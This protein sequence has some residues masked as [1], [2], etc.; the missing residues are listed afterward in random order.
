MKHLFMFSMATCCILM[1]SACGAT[2][3]QKQ[4]VDY[5][6][7]KYETKFTFSDSVDI[8]NMSDEILEIVNE[9]LKDSVLNL[10]ST[11]ADEALKIH[12][13]DFSDDI[14]VEITETENGTVY[15]DNYLAVKNKEAIIDFVNNCIEPYFSEAYIDYQLSDKIVDVDTD[16]TLDDILGNGYLLDIYVAVNEDDYFSDTYVERI[17]ALLGQKGANFIVNF[18]VIPSD[19]FND[20]SRSKIDTLVD[21]DIVVK[22]ANLLKFNETMSLD[23]LK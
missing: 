11:N 4:A 22:Q 19:Q 1:L 8:N 9:D 15:K 14:Y 10:V 16:A 12:S 17:G 23:W 7:D 5:M 20:L 3:E 6:S 2:K 18:V 21:E 13:K